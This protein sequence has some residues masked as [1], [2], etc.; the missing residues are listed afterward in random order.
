MGDVTM[1]IWR[2]DQNGGQFVDYTVPEVEGEVVL[3]VVHRIQAGPAPDL[4]CRWNC[5]AGKCG[6]C[7][8]EINGKP[9]LMCM[10]RMDQLPTEEPIV[11]APMRTFPIIRDLVTDVSFN[12]VMARQ[13]PPLKPRD[14]EPDGTYRMQQVDVERGQEFRKCIECFLCQDVCHVIR[15]H[16]E[17]KP[18]YAG[19]RFF[20]R[21]ME[22]ESHPLDTNDRRELLRQRMGIGLCNITKCCTEVCPEGIKIT[23]N[24]II[25][26]KERVVDGAY[27]PIAWLGRKILRR[28]K[29]SAR[30]VAAD[31]PAAYAPTSEDLGERRA[32][33]ET[34]GRA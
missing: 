6:S 16:E 30:E 22:L 1:R 14:P 26:L 32:V 13:L 18:H 34:A 10:T 29:R 20:I 24:A 5:K 21:Y 4:A 19:P 3:D 12:Y 15:D 31:A 33:P 7:S 8:A 27:D 9:R 23:D 17:N 11:L 2:G 28:T 25:P